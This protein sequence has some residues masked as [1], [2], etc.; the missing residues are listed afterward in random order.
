MNVVMSKKNSVDVGDIDFSKTL[1]SFCQP[2]LVEPNDILKKM[3]KVKKYSPIVYK[4]N[5][6][7]KFL[8]ERSETLTKLHDAY[9]VSYFRKNLIKYPLLDNS[10]FDLKRHIIVQN[11][12]VLSDETVM[13]SL[14]RKEKLGT[15]IRNESRKV[16]ITIPLFCKASYLPEREDEVRLGKSVLGIRRSLGMYR[17]ETGIYATTPRLPFK[18]EASSYKALSAYYACLNE[19]VKPAEDELDVIRYT[20]PKMFIMWIPTEDSLTIRV[21]EIRPVPRDPALILSI[22][23]F[24]LIIDKWDIPNEKPFE[25]YIREYS[26][27]NLN[28]IF[29]K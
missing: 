12:K 15:K 13:S 10:I 8:Q 7:T 24:N 9:L 19:V 17:S 5:E 4:K 21:K 6:V 27:G 20:T 14:T 28:E 22:G 11:S 1:K 3:E 16:L 2:D 29:K 23:D 26:F 18:V 25:N